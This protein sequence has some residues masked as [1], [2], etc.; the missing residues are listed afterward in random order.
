MPLTQPA[1]SGDLDLIVDIT[2]VAPLARSLIDF[3]GLDLDTDL[4]YTLQWEALFGDYGPSLQA[5][6]PRINGNNTVAP[7]I[8]PSDFASTI[9]DF[10]CSAFGCPTLEYPNT[11]YAMGTIS[12]RRLQVSND[13]I[14]F[15][16]Y[17][18]FQTDQLSGPTLNQEGT[19]GFCTQIFGVSLANIFAVGWQ[20]SGQP[21]N[22]VLAGSRFRLYKGFGGNI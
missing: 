4:A 18:Q 1:A 19:P 12:W 14:G 8:T 5:I 6:E 22:D 11:T 7:T 17:V 16:D 13:V 21:V 15:N 3:V 9:C 20:L 2:L 10:T